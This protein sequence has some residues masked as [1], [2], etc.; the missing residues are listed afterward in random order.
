MTLGG[1]C[2][3]R[4]LNLA[5]R[6]LFAAKELNYRRL[7]QPARAIRQR[8]TCHRR[9]YR[10]TVLR[11]PTAHPLAALG[12][13]MPRRVSSVPLACGFH[14]TPPSLEYSMVPN[15]PADQCG[16]ALRSTATKPSGR[17]FGDYT[18]FQT[19][20]GLPQPGKEVGYN[21]RHAGLR[22]SEP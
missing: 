20:S 8:G 1:S 6:L 3:G 22:M 9:V 17:M 12:K 13:L 2:G 4:S 18:R 5:L 7:R 10:R 14:V 21:C 19:S 11:F 16:Q 15:D